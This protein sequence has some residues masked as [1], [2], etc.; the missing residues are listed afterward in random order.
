MIDVGWAALLLGLTIGTMASA[1]FFA[2][3]AF[4]MRIALNTGR[5]VAALILS[6]ALRIAMLLAA[7]WFVAQSGA[8]ALGGFA[9]SFLLVRFI[10]TTLASPK[11]E[12]EEQSGADA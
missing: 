11:L 7:G 10:A 4:G 3:L 9:L 5:P 8:W 12:K 6:A 1:L 2:G